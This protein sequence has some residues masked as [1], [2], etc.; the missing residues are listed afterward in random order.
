MQGEGH[1][2]NRET[3]LVTG[4]SKLPEGSILYSRYDGNFSVMLLLD[5]RTGNILDVDC[6]TNSELQISF[7]R[8]LL[9]GQSLRTNDDV[10]RI[11]ELL[12]H[13]FFSA[14]RKPFYS[15]V[16]ACKKKYDAL[17]EKSR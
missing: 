9:T 1:A 11:G 6:A 8:D 2:S 7:L 15:G 17:I 5:R 14:I 10:E 13:N 3:I 12:E 16:L 4:Y